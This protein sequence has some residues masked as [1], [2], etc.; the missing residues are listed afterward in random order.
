MAEQQVYTIDKF[1]G[2]NKTATETL[3]QLGEASSMTNW[4]I[5]D[6]YKLQKM[7]GYQELFPTLGEHKVN[8]M[9]YG[10]LSGTAHLIFACNGHIYEHDLE[11][12]ENAD[13]GTVADAYP[14]TFCIQQYSLYHGWHRPLFVGR[15]RQLQAWQVMC[16][17]F[18]QQHHQ[19]AA[20]RC[21]SQS[22]T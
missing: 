3:L 18:I 1:L 15:D 12:G 5:T 8:G 22:T 14:T 19:Q 9:W 16:Q 21:W 7:Y 17:R 20:G 4:I 2:V 13:L 11:T 10:T 6:D